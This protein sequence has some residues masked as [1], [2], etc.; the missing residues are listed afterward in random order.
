M[1]SESA[2]STNAADRLNK[3]MEQFNK[4]RMESRAG[5]QHNH[6]EV[7]AEDARKQLPSSFEAKQKDS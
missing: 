5:R 7:V 6:S 3:R 4:L 1:Y 2:P